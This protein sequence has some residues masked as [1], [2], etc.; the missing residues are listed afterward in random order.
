MSRTD[1][2]LEFLDTRTA[3]D[4]CRDP[5]QRPRQ[6]DLCHAYAALL[7]YF[8]NPT[9]TLMRRRSEAIDEPT[10]L[11]TISKVP[12]PSRWVA[13]VVELATSGSYSGTDK[14]DIPGVLTPR[15]WVA[16]EGTSEEA[17]R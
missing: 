2:I 9:R 11:F 1:Q 15:C 17:P 3:N 12:A 14:S 16:F 7:G 4:W 5:R 8:F 13:K 6:G 10:N